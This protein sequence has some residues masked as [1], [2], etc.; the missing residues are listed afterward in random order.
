MAIK[1]DVESDLQEGITDPLMRVEKNLADG[2]SSRGGNQWMVYLSTFVAVCGS[3]EFG[4]CIGYSSPTQSAI[5]ED[6]S[7]TLAEAL[8][9]SCAFC[10]AGWLAIYFSKEAWSLDIGRLANGYGMGAF[11]YVVPVFIAEIAPKNLRGRLTAINQLMICGGVSVSFIIGVLVSWRALA[12]IGLIPCAVNIFGLF[13]IPESPRWLAKKGRHKEFEVALQKLRGKDADISHEAA[14]IQDYIETLDRLPKAKLLDLFQRRYSRS[15]I[16]GVGL[17]V[18]Q[19]FGGI[20]GVCFYVSDIF[21][22]AGFSS[23]IGTITYAILQVVV[24]GIGAAVMDKAGRKPLILVSAS[25]VVLGCLLTAVSFFLKVHELALTATP[26]LAVTGILF[27]IG[28][29]SIGMGAVPWVVMSEIFPINIK[30]QAGSLAT[31]VNWFGA[32]LC[33]YTFNYLMSW[34]SY[35]TFILY[36]AINALAILFVTLMV[37]ETKGKTLEQIQGAINK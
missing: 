31:L 36:A 12:L 3:Y 9:V 24:T 28:S 5:R 37:P 11:S 22:Q 26:I 30:G 27:Y 19:Q 18:C 15:V 16:I 2:G 25:G 8:R 29:F 6:L 14:E 34:S 17:M 35:G 32:W 33:S 23:S 13:F 10:V 4:C 21:Y 1:E 7:L 20:N